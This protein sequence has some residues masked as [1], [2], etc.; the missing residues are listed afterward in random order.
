MRS[1][2]SR[3]GDAGAAM[4]APLPGTFVQ[5]PIGAV[6]SPLQNVR[7]VS[8]SPGLSRAA[9]RRN[10]RSRRL[11]AHSLLLRSWRDCMEPGEER[12]RASVAMWGAMY[13]AD[14]WAALAEGDALRA[15]KL[16]RS[17]A[18]FERAAGLRSAA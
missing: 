7:P 10:E 15:L 11:F 6:P 1:I 8:A 12:N 4:L 17:A 16:H 9:R 14:A 5:A 18:A 3:L 2:L 13:R